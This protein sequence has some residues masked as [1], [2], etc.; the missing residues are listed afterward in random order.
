M[1]YRN[2]LDLVRGTDFILLAT[3]DGYTISCRALLLV[4]VRKYFLAKIASSLGM[5]RVHEH[6]PHLLSLLCT[7]IWSRF[8]QAPT[9]TGSTPPTILPGPTNP[10]NATLPAPLTTGKTNV[11]GMK[12]APTA[13]VAA[14]ASD[15]SEDAAAKLG[16]TNAQHAP[17][18]Q[19]TATSSN[20][21][22]TPN[23]PK[24]A[25]KD[26]ASVL[27]SV[28]PCAKKNEVEKPNVVPCEK[29]AMAAAAAVAS[30]DRS[31]DQGPKLGDTIVLK[32]GQGEKRKYNGSEA[33]ITAY[34]ENGD[35]MTVFVSSKRVKWSKRDYATPLPELKE[36][37]MVAIFRFLGSPDKKE[38]SSDKVEELLWVRD[39]VKVHTQLASVCRS[40]R[41]ICNQDL[42][43]ML[44]RLNANFD[45]LAT[46][47]IIPVA[48]WLVKHK[49][50]IGSLKFD[51]E[52]E[53]LPLLV[54]VLTE[55]D[56]TKLVTVRAYV[57]RSYR[58]WSYK[59]SE[60]ISA[61]YH[62][63]AFQGHFVNLT[64]GSQDISFECK[65]K[66][67]GVPV[68]NMTQ[69]DFH[70]IL[71]SQCPNLATL[72]LTVSMPV[73]QDQ[74]RCSE[75]LSSALFSL[76]SITKLEVGLCGHLSAARGSW[77]INSMVF[78]K[79]IK[80]LTS[81][82]KLSIKTSNSNSFL[83]GRR[84]LILSPTLEILDCTGLGKHV[85]VSCECPKLERFKCDG[86]AYGNG[87]RP[88]F[89]ADDLDNMDSFEESFVKDGDLKVNAG[90]VGFAGLDVP[91]TCECILRDFDCPDPDW[92]LEAKPQCQF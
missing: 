56:T 31:D 68:C 5:E 84:F 33:T 53:D 50:V 52:L 6:T 88:L 1:C 70:D 16:D 63:R 48:Q 77:P 3:A 92:I 90:R 20:S 54:Q 9:S 18:N 23:A 57:D 44:G 46:G 64:N 45:A 10:L 78:Y 26:A 72:S 67:L 21:A 8:F 80:N 62:A 75:Y 71:A 37:V 91:D 89:T 36:E 35:L 28:E 66:Y 17:S 55:C 85:W 83:H 61:A 40:W 69:K 81:L 73:R 59:A 74:V 25:R 30:S 65:A 22:W 86:A 7:H 51:A 15:R 47:T 49:L 39:A 43:V 27:V 2:T 34:P 14:A 24:A 29:S 13:P 60:W 87:T 38:P 12:K 19:T 42:S 4:N 82:T 76:S 11:A 58:R 41:E 79:M 32:G